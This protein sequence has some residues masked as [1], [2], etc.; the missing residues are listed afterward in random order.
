LSAPARDAIASS[1][2][3]RLSVRRSV[4][5]RGGSPVV[6]HSVKMPILAIQD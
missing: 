5:L 3:E 1:R 4:T 6:S 2:R